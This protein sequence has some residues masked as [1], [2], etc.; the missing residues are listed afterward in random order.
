MSSGDS[1]GG[2]RFAGRVAL[3]T[4]GGGGIG[5]AIVRRA[6]ERLGG[7]AGLEPRAEGGSTFWLELAPA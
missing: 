7:R 2:A 1:N 3:V 6:A 5:L 4:G